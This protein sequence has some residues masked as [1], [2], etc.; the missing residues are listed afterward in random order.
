MAGRDDGVVEKHPSELASSQL[1][2]RTA[3]EKRMCLR[4]SLLR[5]RP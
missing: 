4:T 3:V 5:A 1:T 2:E